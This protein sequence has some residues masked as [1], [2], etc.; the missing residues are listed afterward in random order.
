VLTT[1]GNPALL[2][3]YGWSKVLQSLFVRAVVG[4][5]VAEVLLRTMRLL[6]EGGFLA[7]YVAMAGAVFVGACY[8]ERCYLSSVS[9]L[10]ASHRTHQVCP[11][12]W[13][14][15]WLSWARECSGLLW[16]RGRRSRRL[17]SRPAL[18]RYPRVVQERALAC[19]LADRDGD[20]LPRIRLYRLSKKSLSGVSSTEI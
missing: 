1:G 8:M 10:L 4:L 18:G 13:S 20:E 11:T 6:L 2:V 19:T 14:R 5:L 15:F 12:Y 17:D 3:E 16:G 7:R 9:P